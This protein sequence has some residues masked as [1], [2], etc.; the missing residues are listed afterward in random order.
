MKLT[1]LY[2]AYAFGLTY[3][4]W[5]FYLAVMS[6]SRAKKAGMLSRTAIVLGT[7]VLFVGYLLDLLL[8][9]TVISLVLLELPQETTV[10]ARL[11]RHHIESDGWRLAVVMW[12]E[13]LLDPYDPSGDHI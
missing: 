6:L 3:A 10:T 7:P 13:P 4:T 5:I 9:V 2:L 12:F 8:N 1:A 11:K